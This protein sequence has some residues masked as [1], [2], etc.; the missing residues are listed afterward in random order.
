MVYLGAVLGLRWGECAGLRVGHVEF[1]RSTISVAEQITCGRGGLGHSDP[2]LTLA[3]FA[4]ATSKADAA[5]AAAL[6][7]HFM[8]SDADGR[9]RTS[10]DRG[11]DAG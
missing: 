2:R 4:Q 11:I 1:L 8:P 9:A 5:A 6:G 7:A 3:V 10:S